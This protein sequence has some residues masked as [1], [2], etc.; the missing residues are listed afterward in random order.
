MSDAQATAREK[1]TLG[2][3]ICVVLEA[4]IKKLGLDEVF[5]APEWDRAR[6]SIHRD[7]ALG[8]ESLGALWLGPNGAKLGSVILHPDGS[9]FAEYDIIRPHPHRKK[10]FI[11]AVTAWGR[12]G[13]IK[14]EPRL[15]PMPE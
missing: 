13:V 5:P 4:E 8:K 1:S 12:D 9:F 10:W 15:L 3:S 11:E 7:P 6:F 2:R 14:S